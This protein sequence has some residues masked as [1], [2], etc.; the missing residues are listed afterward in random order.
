MLV[1]VLTEDAEF[2][3]SKTALCSSLLDP[4]S[5]AHYAGLSTTTGKCIEETSQA[6]KTRVNYTHARHNLY[7]SFKRSSGRW[8]QQSN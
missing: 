3:C 5:T 2:Y 4:V 1:V 6:V 8:N 7:Q